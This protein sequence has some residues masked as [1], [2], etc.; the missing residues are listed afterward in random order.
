MVNRSIS[1]QSAIKII[2]FYW[3]WKPKAKIELCHVA[4]RFIKLTM[5]IYIHSDSSIQ[6]KVLFKWILKHT[7]KRIHFPIFFIF[8][9]PQFNIN[10]KRIRTSF[11]VKYFSGRRGVSLMMSLLWT[12]NSLLSSTIKRD[13]H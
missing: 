1:N 8:F 5:T 13:V 6:L 3:V 11:E 2:V 7:L 12:T 9:F 10:M 4:V